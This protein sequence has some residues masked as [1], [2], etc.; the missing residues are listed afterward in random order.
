MLKVLVVQTDNRENIDYVGL[1]K[2]TNSKQVDR[3]NK[4]QQDKPSNPSI[5]F[6]YQFIP[7]APHY[8]TNIHPATAKIYV[9]QELLNTSTADYIVF[10]DSDAWIQTPYY[11]IQL[12]HMLNDKTHIHGAYSRDPYLIINDFVNSGSFILK[13]DDYNREMYKEIQADMETDTSHHHAWSYDQ[14]YISKHIFKRK[15]DFLIF[16]PHILNTPD[17]IIL[18]HSWWKNTKLFGDMYAVLDGHNNN[19]FSTPL[20]IDITSFI[21]KAPYPNPDNSGHQYL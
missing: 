20:H 2:L 16:I 7:L 5:E 1:S 19:R 13:I 11:M 21:D 15:D 3:L 14:Y 4:I 10:V 12:L 8:Y 6:T 17:G 18:R 9:L